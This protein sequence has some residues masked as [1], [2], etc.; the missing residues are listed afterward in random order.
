M[1]QLGLLSSRP[2]A[3]ARAF[4]VSKARSVEDNDTVRPQQPIGHTTGVPIVSCD[5][6]TVN[7]NNG[8]AFASVTV[9]Q[10]YAVH[11]NERTLGGMPTL[12]PAR[13]NRACYGEHREAGY[14]GE[15]PPLSA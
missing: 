11:R 3:S 5:R 4:A 8:P 13:G 7:E 2:H 1:D 14:S 9:V 12:C 10:P 15:E 6:I